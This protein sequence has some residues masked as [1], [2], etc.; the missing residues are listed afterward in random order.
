MNDINKMNDIDKKGTW[1]KR[2]S[3]FH[4]LDDKDQAGIETETDN[5][6]EKRGFLEIITP[7]VI[8]AGAMVTL[9]IVAWLGLN[10]MVPQSSTSL[11]KSE[12]VDVQAQ[13]VRKVDTELASYLTR[14]LKL[15]AQEAKNFWPV[16]NDYTNR[17]DKLDQD[18]NSLL[19]QITR[20]FDNLT[21]EEIIEAGNKIIELG[22]QEARL[23]AEY[24]N[25]FEKVLPSEKIILLY[26]AEAKYKILQF[27]QLQHSD[28]Q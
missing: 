12:S 16:Y 15:T 2:Y 14:S 24:H 10:L 17:R 7:F 4:D 8:M 6:G 1:W 25:K 5:Q 21:R 27:N 23:A 11:Q 28:K 20:S 19:E 13:N 3:Y 9:A 18:K 22:N 26:G